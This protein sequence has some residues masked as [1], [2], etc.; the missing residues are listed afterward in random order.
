[1]SGSSVYHPTHITVDG[2]VHKVAKIDEHEDG[3]CHTHRVHLGCG[4]TV[5]VD[6]GGAKKAARWRERADHALA[7]DRKHD[8]KEHLKKALHEEAN[9]HTW[10]HER[11][12]H[13]GDKKMATCTHCIDHENGA[14]A[15]VHDVAHTK[16]KTVLS[17]EETNISCPEC[18][19]R[20]YKRRATKGEGLL[21]YACSGQGHEFTLEQLAT[22]LQAGMASLIALSKK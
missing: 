5:D 16:P 14:D 8:H 10:K 1:M 3:P 9:G 20:I 22:H 12:G 6:I 11:W 18:G 17:D 4:I 21:D 13:H 7:E 2:K 19:Y 15:I